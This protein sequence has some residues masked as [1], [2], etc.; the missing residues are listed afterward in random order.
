[1]TQEEAEALAAGLTAELLKAFPEL[2]AAYDA[3]KAGNTAKFKA[4]IIKTDYYKKRVTE[5]AYAAI[6]GIVQ[7]NGLTK[8]IP[9]SQIESYRNQIV[10]RVKTTTQ[11]ETELRELA[12]GAFPAFANEIRAGYD[13][14]SLAGAYKQAMGTILEVDPNT[15]DLMDPTLY[16][17]LNVKTD[18]GK[19]STKPLW[20]FMQDLRKDERW[21]YTNNAREA[22]DTVGRQILKDFGLVS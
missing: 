17:A 21:R 10:N 16:S 12:A 22:V 3:F 14:T 2:Q 6:K 1:M 9:D 19:V 15:V 18:D 11:I 4:E 5:D 20:Q 7:K 8:L 13:V